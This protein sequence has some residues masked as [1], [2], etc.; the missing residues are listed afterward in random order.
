MGGHPAAKAAFEAAER[1]YGDPA[2]DRDWSCLA[3]GDNVSPAV[4]VNR[5]GGPGV[6]LRKSRFIPGSFKECCHPI[7]IAMAGRRV[8][9]T[10][11]PLFFERNSEM[12]GAVD[13]A[14]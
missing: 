12:A 14:E 8:I 5:S 6:K 3:L 10:F 4:F 11:L 13:R 2:W 9:V 1:A 7:A